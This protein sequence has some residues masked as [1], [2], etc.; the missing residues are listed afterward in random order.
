MEHLAFGERVLPGFPA[1]DRDSPLEAIRVQGGDEGPRG[2]QPLANRRQHGFQK[3]AQV[4]LAEKAVFQVF[5]QA[6]VAVFP[7]E[8]PAFPPRGEEDDAVLQHQDGDHHHERH[9]GI[10][11]QTEAFSDAARHCGGSQH[12]GSG[13]RAAQNPAEH[14]AFDHPV[15]PGDAKEGQGVGHHHQQDAH[16]DVAGD[17]RSPEEGRE[18]QRPTCPQQEIGERPQ[19]RSG[20]AGHQVKHPPAAGAGEG[21][22]VGP[23]EVDRCPKDDGG[24]VQGKKPGQIPRLEGRSG[25]GGSQGGTHQPVAGQQ[26]QENRGQHKIQAHRQAAASPRGTPGSVQKGIRSVKVRG[27]QENH[28]DPF[29]LQPGDR[30]LFRGAGA[31]QRFPRE[32]DGH[33]GQDES[34]GARHAVLQVEGQDVQEQREGG[35]RNACGQQL[36]ESAKDGK[37]H[38]GKTRPSAVTASA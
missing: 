32:D 29:Q 37:P 25:S 31:G 35:N 18:A 7:P 11:G 16:G 30:P 5:E 33:A 8:K 10:V 38:T 17:S 28:P 13:H 3:L 34:E 27:G 6:D 4:F 23:P 22:P 21:A 36:V 26:P 12:S 15:G 1:P 20:S 2:V 9:G 14:A 24:V 19:R